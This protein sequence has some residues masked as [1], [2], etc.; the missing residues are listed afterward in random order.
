MEV[1]IIVIVLVIAI[2]VLS[3]SPLARRAGELADQEMHAM[4]PGAEVDRQFRRPSNEGD[5]L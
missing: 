4:A 2:V 1:V 5:L 3:L